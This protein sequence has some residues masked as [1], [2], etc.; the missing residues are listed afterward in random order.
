M[1]SQLDLD[2]GGTYREW[3]PAW[4]GPSVGWIWMPNRNALS[5]VTGGTFTLDP[6]TSL[7][8]INAAA[9]VIIVLPSAIDPS[10][11][12]GA[13]PGRF[14]KTPVSVVDTGGNA[15]AFPITI[16]PTSSSENVLGLSQI[17]ISANYGGYILY[18]NSTLKGWTNQS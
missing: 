1:S 18:P 13:L 7:V 15:G 16:Q 17:Q 12:A 9:S 11:P 2:Q 5:V 14:A 3:K 10:V 8:E 4:L 6:S